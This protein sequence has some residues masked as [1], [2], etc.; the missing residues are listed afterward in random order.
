VQIGQ[1]WEKFK[2]MAD[3]MRSDPA[4]YG[5]D[6]VASAVLDHMLNA[7]DKGA[8]MRTPSSDGGGVGSRVFLCLRAVSPAVCPPPSPPARP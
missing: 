4:K 5:S 2:R 3:V 6:A 8:C 1:A 7:L